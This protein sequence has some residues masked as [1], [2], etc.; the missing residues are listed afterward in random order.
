MMGLVP[1]RFWF[2]SESELVSGVGDFVFVFAKVVHLERK[3]L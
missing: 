3:G 1:G 2:D